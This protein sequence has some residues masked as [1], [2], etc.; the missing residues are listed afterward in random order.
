MATPL[1]SCRTDSRDVHAGH[2]RNWSDGRRSDG[3]DFAF[4][5]GHFHG[6]VFKFLRDDILD[7]QLLDATKP[8]FRSS[9]ARLGWRF[10]LN[11]HISYKNV[12]RS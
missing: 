1:T 4:R 11:L 5:D 3:G 10:F 7:A 9:L 2:R 12:I 6:D 8:P